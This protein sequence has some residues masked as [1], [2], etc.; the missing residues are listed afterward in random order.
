MLL[1]M[2]QRVEKLKNYTM[3]MIIMRKIK[4]FSIEIEFNLYIY[5]FVCRHKSDDT[6]EKWLRLSGKLGITNIK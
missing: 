1:F 2:L 3:I 4:K 5:I 6:I